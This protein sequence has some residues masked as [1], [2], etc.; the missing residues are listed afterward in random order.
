MIKYR[1]LLLLLI[2]LV[3]CSKSPPQN[4][5]LKIAVLSVWPTYEMVFIAQDKGLFAK[6]GVP[7][8]LVPVADYVDGLELYKENKV[9]ATFMV[10]TDAVILQAEGIATRFVYTTSYSDSGDV[11][12]GQPTLKSL[13]D[14]QGK[15]VSFEGFNT[16]SHLM[17]LKLLERVGL[18]EGD[19][20]VASVDNTNVLNALETKQIEAGH[21]YGTVIPEALA[22]GYKILEIAGN[23]PHLMVEGLVVNGCVV[24]TR[25][26]DVQKVV[27]ALAE[28]IDWFQHFPEEGFRIIAKHNGATAAELATILK[29]MRVFTLEENR[30]A[31]KHTGI[32]FKGGKEIS[33]FFHQKGTLFNPPDLD[34]LID[35]Q[36]INNL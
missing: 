12:M 6:H 13:S 24:T 25:S 3:S 29:R 32:L 15:K 11:I 27:K 7:V 34:T 5:P 21:A 33:D 8:T 1:K 20:Q 9:D 28:A 4:S 14:L 26:A 35:G 2:L 31:F 16:F 19:F 30:E 18:Q 36:F 17:V 10:L 23:I 22:K